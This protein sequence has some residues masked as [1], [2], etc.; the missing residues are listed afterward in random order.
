MLEQDAEGEQFYLQGG[1]SSPMPGGVDA[2]VEFLTVVKSF[3]GVHAGVGTG[4]VSERSATPFLT[5]W[6]LLVML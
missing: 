6:F 3:H 5:R 1:G 4:G 2:A